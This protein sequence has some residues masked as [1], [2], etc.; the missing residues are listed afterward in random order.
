MTLLQSHVPFSLLI[1]EDDKPACDL[2]A[3]IVASEFPHCAIYK[4]YNGMQGIELFKQLKP[5]IILTD[6]SMPVM[7]GF[8]M[9]REINLVHRKT[10]FIVLTAFSDQ[11]TYDKF[12][13]LDVCRYLL[14]PLDFTELFDAI[15]KC[16]ADITHNESNSGSLFH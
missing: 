9:I 5:S 11:L 15:E 1:V 12:R 14:K 16:S 10:S 13:E 4:A 8:E 6:I 3:K 2:I 7:G